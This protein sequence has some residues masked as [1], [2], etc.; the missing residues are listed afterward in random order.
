MNNV[1]Q[2]FRQLLCCILVPD[3]GRLPAEVW[4]KQRDETSLTLTTVTRS[5]D[6]VVI[7]DAWGRQLD[8]Y[9]L[10]RLVVIEVNGAKVFSWNFPFYEETPE[11]RLPRWLG[12][13]LA[14]AWE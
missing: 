9:E 1:L 8:P 11:P 2:W 7:V 6:K 14:A 12:R 10:R 5:G 13:L 4:E 3:Y